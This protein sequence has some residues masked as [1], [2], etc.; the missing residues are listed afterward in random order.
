M[1][2]LTPPA[3]LIPECH[4]PAFLGST[5]GDAV[6]HAVQLQ[7]AFRECHIE[8]DTLNQWVKQHQSNDI[9]SQSKHLQGTPKG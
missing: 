3:S 5:Y 6:E 7:G 4:E 1:H 2:Y 8:I 9:S